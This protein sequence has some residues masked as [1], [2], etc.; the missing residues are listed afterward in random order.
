MVILNKELY[1]IIVMNL[2]KEF[3]LLLLSLHFKSVLELTLKLALTIKRE[4]IR[5]P[6][7]KIHLLQKVKEQINLRILRLRSILRWFNRGKNLIKLQIARKE[8]MKLLCIRL[9][10][11]HRSLNSIKILLLTKHTMLKNK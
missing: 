10:I 7:Y 3:I 5:I 9:L 8:K 4:A 6:K 2:L 11:T 1:V